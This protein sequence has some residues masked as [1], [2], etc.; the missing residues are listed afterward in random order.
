MRFSLLILVLSLF[1]QGCDCPVTSPSNRHIGAVDNHMHELTALIKAR[2]KIKADKA[3]CHS[4]N[5][6][7]PVNSQK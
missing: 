2:E 6:L 4:A 7:L 5:I 1:L 3:A